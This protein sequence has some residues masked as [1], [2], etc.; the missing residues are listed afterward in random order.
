[1]NDF[2]D[3]DL[4]EA[5]LGDGTIICDP[6]DFWE[7]TDDAQVHVA[8]DHQP[9]DESQVSPEDPI[10]IEVGHQEAQ[11]INPVAATRLSLADIQQAAGNPVDIEKD[12]KYPPIPQHDILLGSHHYSHRTVG[13]DV[14]DSDVRP[15]HHREIS[16]DVPEF[17]R[18]VHQ[19]NQAH[20]PNSPFPRVWIGAD[21]VRS[22]ADYVYE[23]QLH[24][25]AIG[26]VGNQTKCYTVVEASVEYIRR[27]HNDGNG[28]WN[29]RRK[30]SSNGSS[31]SSNNN[32]GPGSSGG[33]AAN[34]S[35]GSAGNSSRESFGTNPQGSGSSSDT[36]SS[37]EGGGASLGND[38]SGHSQGRKYTGRMASLLNHVE[39]HRHRRRPADQTVSS[40]RLQFTELQAADGPQ[41]QSA[42]LSVS[43]APELGDRPN[44]SCYASCLSVHKD[45]IRAHDLFLEKQIETATVPDK[46][47]ED[48]GAPVA[49]KQRVLGQSVHAVDPPEHSNCEHQEHFVQA[50][51][52]TGCNGKNNGNYDSGLFGYCMGSPTGPTHANSHPNLQNSRSGIDTYRDD[53]TVARGGS[54]AEQKDSIVDNHQS[55]AP[56][57][58][59]A[60]VSPLAES[61]SI[62]RIC[63]G[64]NET[65]LNTSPIGG[66][67]DINITN[68][69]FPQ[70]KISNGEISS[71]FEPVDP[72]AE[73]HMPGNHSAPLHQAFRGPKE[74]LEVFCANADSTHNKRMPEIFLV[75]DFDDIEQPTQAY[76]LDKHHFPIDLSNGDRHPG[77][78]CVFF[79]V[80]CAR[81]GPFSFLM[82]S[83]Q[84]AIKRLRKRIVHD[85]LAQGGQEN[86]YKEAA[87]MHE[88]GDSEHVLEL[89]EFLEDEEYLYIVT[90]MATGKYQTLSDAI[91]WGDPRNVME[92]ER[93][94]QI[95]AK[96]LKIIYYLHSNNV[97]HRDLSPSN[98]LFLTD[99]NL[100]AFD[101][102]LSINIPIDKSTGQRCLISPQGRCG[103]LPFMAPEVFAHH[104][105]DGG[106]IDLWG[107][108]TILYCLLT[109][110]LLYKAPCDGDPGFNFF[111]CARNLSINPGN[112]KALAMLDGIDENTN[113]K[114]SFRA[115]AHVYI[116]DE[117]LSLLNNLLAVDP[118]KR[119]TLSQ[120]MESKYVQNTDW[121]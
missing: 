81:V 15:N 57:D 29:K 89:V 67:K 79:G 85:Y 23:A 77:W 47:H 64:K 30:T 86:P 109:N 117:A 21:K 22:E 113:R 60:V 115:L 32:Q 72:P 24:T 2:S 101:L 28:R 5:I 100:V 38:S 27:D 119:Y 41:Y 75:R 87:R 46:K 94:K 48:S 66:S 106:A 39:K 118:A 82:T 56:T 17:M 11:Q 14:C 34:G 91:A 112:K 43:C 55:S 6:C 95:F 16:L 50:A 61:F 116:S 90:P 19:A 120:A 107:A 33:S 7:I 97:C 114:L 52:V 70:R 84:V 37:T 103:T 92:P 31:G 69:K 71:A 65:R 105:F 44:N 36:T 76:T 99:E 13:N 26:N 111:V 4:M 88:L 98:F 83:K 40:G 74:A 20:M 45:K 3:E 54:D 12:E 9:Q 10:V 102:A 25:F 80:T 1:M 35:S 96:I 62:L 121:Q 59:S 49:S 51:S 78:G 42:A 110:Q 68:N 73:H 108:A 104:P 58:L 93:V 8:H 63:D 53:N 18:Q